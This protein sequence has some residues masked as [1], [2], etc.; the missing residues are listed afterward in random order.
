MEERPPIWRVAANILKK[1]IADNRKMVVLQLGELGEVLTTP[2]RKK[3]ILL[4][5]TYT[6][7]LVNAVMNIRVS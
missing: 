1:A 2:H 4:R 3:R 7:A 5:N 6:E